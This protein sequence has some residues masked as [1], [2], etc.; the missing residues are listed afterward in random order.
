MKLETATALAI[1]LQVQHE[2]LRFWF[3][4]GDLTEQQSKLESDCLLALQQ[5]THDGSVFRECATA[6][7]QESDRNQTKVS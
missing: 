6:S 7:S 1:L 3:D 4:R 2:L 5:T